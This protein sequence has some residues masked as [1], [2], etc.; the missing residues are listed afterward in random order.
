[1]NSTD[2]NAAFRPNDQGYI[3]WVGQGNQLTQGITN[4][5]WR[6]RLDLGQGPWGNRT[7][8]GMPIALRDSTGAIA[9]VP[10]GN[11]LP[12]NHPGRGIGL[13]IWHL[14]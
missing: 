14:S 6:S 13:F 3:V 5:L 9:N 12:K 7:N 4:N 10:V 1:M 2:A 8:W 11:A